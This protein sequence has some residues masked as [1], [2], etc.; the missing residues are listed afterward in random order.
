LIV[1]GCSAILG[2]G[3]ALLWLGQGTFVAE[4]TKDSKYKGILISLFFA[5]MQTS[6]VLGNL[7]GGLVLRGAD[8]F[9]LIIAF[10]IL[11]LISNISF[12]FLKRVPIT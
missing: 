3:A 8:L 2:C 10:L 9:T 6:Q 1:L 5:I 11:S 4:C 12:P 7:L